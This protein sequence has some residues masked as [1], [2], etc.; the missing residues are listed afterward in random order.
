[1]EQDRSIGD[2]CRKIEGV[3]VN[4]CDPASW[5]SLCGGLERKS[6]KIGW[7][8]SVYLYL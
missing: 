1:M 3:A 8:V 5:F 6:Q 7:N 2:I 4:V